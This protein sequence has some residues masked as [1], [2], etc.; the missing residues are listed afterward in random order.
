MDD[1][2][3]T[4]NLEIRDDV[5]I[6]RYASWG[7]G[8]P[9]REWTALT[10]LAEHAPGLA[11]APVEAA[12]DA[13]PPMIVMSRLPGTVL[14]GQDATD[15]QITAMAAA[16]ARLH[17]A[18]PTRVVEAVT[19][20][21]WGPATAVNKYRAWAHKQPNL[22]DDPI[23]RLAYHEGAAWLASTDPDRLTTNPFPPV[24]GLADGNRANYLWDRDEGRVRLI[25]WEDSGSNDRAFEVGE[26]V[27]H[28]SRVDG[29]LDAERLLA[30]I[31]LAPRE[32]ER[33]LGF[34]R[35][36]A[37]GWMLQLGPDGP[38]TPH[39]PAGTLER[40]AERVLQVLG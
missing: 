1:R 36:V 37:L 38:A 23:V 29:D 7:R 25:D 2:F 24:L 17:Q 3:S 20:A 31:D 14:R 6:K 28:I 33:V 34:R 18:I 12:L 10:L 21:P 4:H 8:E 40:L 39:N 9:H 5:V 35:L 16:L 26:V 30:L 27:E 22:G 13:Y 11:P 15:K 32:A 19:P